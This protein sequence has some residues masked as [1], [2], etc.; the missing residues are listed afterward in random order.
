MFN[1]W[2]LAKYAVI[3]RAV[4]MNWSLLVMERWWGALGASENHVAPTFKK[5]APP[6][7]QNYTAPLPYS[8]GFYFVG[9][10]NLRPV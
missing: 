7:I 1:M 8:D 10:R 2:I 4:G 3:L 5:Y 6:S 9:L